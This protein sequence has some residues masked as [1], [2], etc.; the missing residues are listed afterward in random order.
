MTSY[1]SSPAK[2]SVAGMGR[3]YR[4]FCTLGG[5]WFA[6]VTYTEEISAE[7]PA[8]LETKVDVRRIHE[9]TATEADKDGSNRN[10]P[11]PFVLKIVERPEWI[12]HK[13]GMRLLQLVELLVNIRRLVVRST[14]F[15]MSMGGV[16][17]ILFLSQWRA[18]MQSVNVPMQF[19]V[20][21][22]LHIGVNMPHGLQ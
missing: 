11:S 9:S 19:T 3:G 8:S 20:F 15:M 13:R 4:A 22:H 18:M 10:D 12:V 2:T 14:D 21:C 6:Q 17:H 16:E 5:T 1:F 7:R